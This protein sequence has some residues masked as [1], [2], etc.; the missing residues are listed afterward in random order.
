MEQIASLLCG[1]SLCALLLCAIGLIL[2]L[3]GDISASQ[4]LSM[5]IVQPLCSFSPEELDTISIGELCFVNQGSRFVMK[6][7]EELPLCDERLQELLHLLESFPTGAPT[8]MPQQEPDRTLLLTPI[9]G[10]PLTLQFFYMEETILVSDGS[11]CHQISSQQLAPF[12]LPAEDYADTLIFKM[13]LPSE[14]NL[15]ISG[16]VH[17]EALQLSFY[18]IGENHAQLFSRLTAPLSAEIPPNEMEN[19]IQNLCTLRGDSVACLNPDE[20]DL[21]QYGLSQPFLTIYGDFQSEQFQLQL[22]APTGDNLFYVRKNDE[23]VIYTLSEDA[24][25]FLSLCAKSLT[26]E[27]IFTA[28]YDDC[29]TLL[30][31]TEEK[32]YRFTKWDGIVLC[33][34]QQVEEK[35]FANFFDFSTKLIPCGVAL[36]EQQNNSAIFSLRL[37]YT[38]PQAPADV[39]EFFPYDETRLRLSVNGDARFLCEKEKVQEIFHRCES[40]F[41]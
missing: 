13:P 1:F 27:E 7:M 19:I 20:Q 23:P 32:S 5:P 18:Y 14:G 12:L 38:N 10:S 33:G 22:S 25:P 35:R 15:C 2:P 3:Q 29:T 30:F 16:D 39:I 9:N 4:S 36:K 24:L 34:G 41:R 26:R 21:Q 31:S 11:R 6:G 28:D 37:S 8:D 40:L 17:G